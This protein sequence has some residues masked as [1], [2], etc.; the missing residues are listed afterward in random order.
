MVPERWARIGSAATAFK[1]YIKQMLEEETRALNNG[2]PGSGGLMTSFV[3]ALHTHDRESALAGARDTDSRKGLSVEEVFSNLFVINFA[4]HDTTAN[5]LAFIML[6]L[7]AQPDVQA[8]MAEE[9]EEVAQGAPVHEWDYKTIYPRLHRCRAVLLETLR[10]YPPVMALPKWTS[11]RTQTL[12]VED[13]MFTIPPG[14]SILLYLR[15]IQTH[16]KYWPDPYS[17]LPSRWVRA[18]TK[19]SSTTHTMAHSSEE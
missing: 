19:G 14:T 7:A 9:I 1:V 6:L 17:W 3:H 13:R 16:P 10:L 18:T 15:A 11:K 5:T 4:G 8:W 2:Q 12:Q